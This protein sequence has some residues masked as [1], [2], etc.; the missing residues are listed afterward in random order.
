MFISN[1]VQHLGAFV[2]CSFLAAMSMFERKVASDAGSL[3][4]PVARLRIATS[5][6]DADWVDGVR[7]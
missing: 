6:P 4:S 7:K 2:T 1:R 5:Y 3:H